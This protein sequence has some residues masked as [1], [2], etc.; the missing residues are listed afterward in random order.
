MCMVRTQHHLGQSCSRWFKLE[1]GQPQA[2]L[3]LDLIP[4][5]GKCPNWGIW[6]PRLQEHVLEM[7]GT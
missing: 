1:V 3:D 2:G 5:T 6:G 7:K 4:S